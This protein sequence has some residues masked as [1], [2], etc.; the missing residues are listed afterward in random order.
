MSEESPGPKDR[1]IALPAAGVPAD[2]GLSSLGLVM[3]LAGTVTAL[4]VALFAFSTLLTRPD[5]RGDSLW[6]F[7]LLGTC[8]ARSLFHRMSGTE[9]LYGRTIDGVH[10]LVALKRYV[11]IG[12]VHS[13]VFAL[14]LK[15]KFDLPARFAVGVG[16]GFAV[17]PALLGALMLSSLFRRFETR[18]PV[19]EDKGFEGAS[20]LMAVLG[21]C[22]V[23]ATGTVLVATFESDGRGLRDGKNVLLMLA[24]VMLIVRSVLHVQAG[25]SGLRTTSID[26]SVE[27]SNRYASFGI[28]SAFCAGGAMLLVVMTERL[29][30]SSLAAVT[31]ITW[32]L[33]TW[34]MCVRRFFGDR[35]FADLLAGENADVHRRAPD[36]GLTCLG[37]LLLA[38][39]AYGA[40]MLVPRMVGGDFTTDLGG[41][42]DL[43]ASMSVRSP[44]W[45]VGSAMLEGWAGFELIRM[46]AHHRVISTVYAVVASAVT[47]YMFWPVLQH[48]DKLQLKPQHLLSVMPIGIALVIPVSTLIL[49]NRKI[50]PSARARFR[51][52]T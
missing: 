44:W 9:L 2:Q 28:V 6:M 15:F 20:I 35:Q 51:A 34:P 52:R 42:F 3:Q 10:P 29:D 49:V 45:S 16:L 46:T 24:L 31:G 37:W 7:L 23:L 21:V 32:M 47:L 8:V 13:V 40:T 33:M 39:A 50:A 19:S 11:V 17:W 30:V 22:G 38:H 48:L 26:R 4:G 18:I 1:V 36:A 12:L 43:F 14:A 25:V 41:G 27:L 5:H